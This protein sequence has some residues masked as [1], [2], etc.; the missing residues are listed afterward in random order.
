MYIIIRVV[1]YVLTCYDSVFDSIERGAARPGSQP[2][3]DVF[4]THVYSSGDTPFGGD[5]G[6]S[7]TS[8]N[9]RCKLKVQLVVAA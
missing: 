6:M 9:D 8:T 1:L 7:L 3:L 5:P 2:Y 4:S